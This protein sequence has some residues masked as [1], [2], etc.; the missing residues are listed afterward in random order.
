ME[1][2]YHP[3]ARQDILSRLARLNPQSP[4]Q[5]G[6][7]DAAQMLGHCSA[8]LEVVTGQKNPPRLFIGRILA[9][10]LRSS[11]TSD[12]PFKKNN[13]THKT[14]IVADQRDFD[15]ERNQLVGLV[16]QFGEGGEAKCTRH[17]HAFF[18]PLTPREWGIG[19]YKHLDHHLKQFGA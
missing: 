4:R 1:T 18:G 19:M 7:M 2:L 8:V 17:P 12:Q 16:N 3:Q 13:P 10:F 5:W 9:P 14:F 6:K 11:F 15:R